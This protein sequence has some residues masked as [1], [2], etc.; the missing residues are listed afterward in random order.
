MIVVLVIKRES[1]PIVGKPGMC[2]YM[3]N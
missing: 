2:D 3:D 1:L